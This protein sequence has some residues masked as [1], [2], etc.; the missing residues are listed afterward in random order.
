MELE[1]RLKSRDFAYCLESYDLPVSIAD[2]ALHD[3]G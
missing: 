3:I 1:G 2:L